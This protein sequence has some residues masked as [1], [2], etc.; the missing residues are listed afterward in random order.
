MPRPSSVRRPLRMPV[1][2]LVATLLPAVA[3]AWLG[4]RLIEQEQSLERQRV[5]DLLE[6]TANSITASLERELGAIERNLGSATINPDEPQ[7]DTAITVRV[8]RQGSATA[9]A[10]AG[11]A[12]EPVAAPPREPPPDALWAEA[13]RL[14]YVIRDLPGAI[15]A[16]RALI[17]SPNGDV[18][19]GALIRL[20]RTLKRSGRADEA[21]ETYSQL[22]AVPD[23]TILGDPAELMA[24]WARVELLAAL[25]RQEVLRSEAAALDQ[26]LGTAVGASIAPLR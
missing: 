2:F 15:R 3:L 18:R 19:A 17:P 12:H 13:E 8:D 25:E 16:Y 20:A 21:L 5:Q 23:A 11:L 22:A 26:D 6:S 14:E 1:L 7:S 4:W 10:G 9:I 24:R